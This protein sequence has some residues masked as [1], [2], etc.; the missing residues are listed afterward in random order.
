MVI[1]CYRIPELRIGIDIACP[2]PATL[3]VGVAGL[4]GEGQGLGRDKGVRVAPNDAVYQT[5][6]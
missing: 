2:S 5:G 6:R 4:K 1:A 3:D